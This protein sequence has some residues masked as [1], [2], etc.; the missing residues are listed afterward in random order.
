[1]LQCKTLIFFPLLVTVV[2]VSLG[3]PNSCTAQEREWVD[4]TGKHKIEG[5]FEKLE[6]GHVFL[7]RGDGVA[8]K[9]PLDQ[10]GLTDQAH[11]R[12]IMRA[13]S[14]TSPLKTGPDGLP[15]K[16]ND[17]NA[18]PDNRAKSLKIDAPGVETEFATSSDQKFTSGIKIERINQLPDEI[19]ELA[20]SLH[21]RKNV[22]SVGKA[23]TQLAEQE[24]LPQ[25]VID[26][27]RETSLSENRYL[28][29][30]STKLLGVFDSVNSFDRI[31][32]ALDDPSLNVRWVALEL[33]QILEDR[34]A[35]DELIARFPG[36]D[37]SK[38][39]GVLSGFGPSIESKV[40]PLVEHENRT[41]VIDA[42]SLLTKIGG[43][44]SIKR[45]E[46]FQDSENI[47]L[48][49]HCASAIRKIQQRLENE[50]QQ[51]EDQ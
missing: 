31:I 16:K 37:R 15:I 22:V 50:K 2:L 33:I 27:L 46:S 44:Q 51:D 14:K 1:M 30:Q 19:R 36:P 25:V 3:M 20:L 7:R 12:E 8:I 32:D 17:P 35:I 11:V 43:K 42:V 39:I 23:F 28:R 47:T 41:V 21:Q 13:R 45:L 34:R 6:D 18:N 29:V 49:L 26:L 48:R 38:I 40:I 5:I 4:R 24:S 10:L 9:I